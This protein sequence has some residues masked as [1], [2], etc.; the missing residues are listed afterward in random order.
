MR[1]IL[2]ISIYLLLPLSAGAYNSS[3]LEQISNDMNK[4]LPKPH[5]QYTTWESTYY[6]QGIM[7]YFYKSDFK[8][9]DFSR[10]DLTY[11]KSGYV[12]VLRNRFCSFY[13]S[14]VTDAKVKKAFQGLINRYITYDSQGKTLNDI[15]ISVDS[16]Y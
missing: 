14:T 10:S 2:L 6:S 15:Q 7:T 5:D 4:T 11:F 3:F 13:K 16:C 9:S 8:V 12:D 1:K